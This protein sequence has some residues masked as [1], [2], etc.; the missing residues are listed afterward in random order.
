MDVKILKSLENK[1]KYRYGFMWAFFCA[2]LWGLWY[3]PGYLVW[4]AE[5][6]GDMFMNIDTT[7]GGSAAY[8]VTAALISAFNAIAVIVA[9]LI[10]NLYLGKMGELKRTLV[11]FKT[12]SKW[13]FAAGIFGLLA[14]YGTY[15]AG[16]YIGAGFAAVAGLLYPLIG[17]MLAYFWYGE[18]IT[19]RGYIGILLIVIG[20][21]SIYGGQFMGEVTGGIPWL[22]LAGG[23]MAAIGWGVEGAV[24]GKALDMAEPDAGLTIRFIS[25]GGI[26]L[27][28]LLPLFA[29]MGYPIYEY[30][31]QVFTPITIMILAFAGLTFGYCYV[32]WYKSFP[33]IGVGKGQAIGNLYGLFAVI[34]IWLFLGGAPTSTTLIGGLLCITGSFV[35]FGEDSSDIDSLRGD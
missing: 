26:W 4:V 10:W 34:F 21:V 16:G 11:Q 22:G 13:F 31:I 20:G 9:L 27:L 25:E 2:L 12:C 29:L 5:P 1:K 15:I 3:V 6:F 17:S 23:L 19:K 8:V 14:V 32:T 28:V 33:L 35:I 18:R 7:S 30:A 24:A